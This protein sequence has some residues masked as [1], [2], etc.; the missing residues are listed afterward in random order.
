MKQKTRFELFDEF[1]NK[2]VSGRNLQICDLGCGYGNTISF[3]KNRAKII[4]GLDIDKN[5]IK[6]CKKGLKEIKKLR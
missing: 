5:S 1:V 6:V 3:L 4:Y 2:N